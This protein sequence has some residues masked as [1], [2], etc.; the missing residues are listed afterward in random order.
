MTLPQLVRYLHLPEAQVKKLVARDEI[1][2]RRVNGELVFSRNDVHRWLEEK[3]GISDNNELKEVETALDNSIPAGT[4]EDAVSLN[5]LI[6]ENAVAVP[7]QAKTRDS[8]IRSMIQLAAKTGL[9]WDTEIMF[10]AVKAR[11]EL[12][13]TALD[14]GIALLHSRQPLPNILGDTFICIGILPGGIHFGGGNFG[15]ITDILFLICSVDDRIHLRILT[16]LSRL[17]KI[18]GFIEG[19]REQETEQGIRRWIQENEESIA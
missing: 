2:S 12:H 16:R 6:P 5:S 17:L 7:L 11:E 8:A 19:L 4:T 1:P 14:N 3:I 18:D 15:G 10:D 13:S 9:L